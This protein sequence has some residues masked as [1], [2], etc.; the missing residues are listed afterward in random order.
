MLS[1]VSL[2]STQV[3][4]DSGLLL[5]SV[6]ERIILSDYSATNQAI[7]YLYFQKLLSA[8]YDPL[9]SIIFQ[10]D[11][12]QTVQTIV[13]P[14]LGEVLATIGSIFSILMMLRIL[15]EAVSSFQLEKQIMKTILYTYFPNLQMVAI[16]RNIL[17]KITRVTCEEKEIDAVSF[18]ASYE[19]AFDHLQ[20]YLELSKIIQK[21]IILEK[22][23]Q[24]V[25]SSI[26][27]RKKS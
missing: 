3:Q 9:Y 6:S 14:K 22:K 24:L 16:Q 25:P 26:D 5:P 13:K 19:K 18:E 17:G 12:L 4:Y 20:C 7:T 27:I 11:N 10:I 1:T 8:N 15:G 21:V 2:F 23:L